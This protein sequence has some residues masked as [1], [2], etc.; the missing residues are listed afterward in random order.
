ML[1]SAAMRRLGF[2]AM[3][4]LGCGSPAKRSS[5]VLAPGE[6]VTVSAEHAR[7]EPTATPALARSAR[8]ML[9]TWAAQRGD[10]ELGDHIVARALSFAGARLGEPAELGRGYAPDVAASPVGYVVAWRPTHETNASFAFAN[11]D[12]DAKLASPPVLAGEVATDGAPAMTAA[13]GGITAACAHGD[14]D[15][16]VVR[17][18]S[19]TTN[20]ERIPIRSGCGDVQVTSVKDAAFA[21]VA[22][23]GFRRTE[24]IALADPAA[25]SK[26]RLEG[27]CDVVP[28][29]DKLVFVCLDEPDGRVAYLRAETGEA[30]RV[31]IDFGGR[32]H[33][34][35]SVGLDAG[36][37]LVWTTETPD[38]FALRASVVAPD[39]SARSPVVEISPTPAV[40]R[41]DLEGAS[42]E[43][44]IVYVTERQVEPTR[45]RH[46]VVVI[47]LRV[48]GT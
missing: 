19:R 12:D 47:P 18:P 40:P 41:F 37:L 21:A 10:D 39:G 46:D 2:L 11:V 20:A 26:V 14:P 15:V 44:W 23:D 35:R 1:G 17:H 38:G 34:L 5:L 3:L 48:T 32:V 27:Q 33:K 13:R 24:I 8:R 6:P 31:S 22:T 25:V 7:V 9:V 36:I 16:I 45:Y 30:K 28:D 4:A 43:A 29:R 42:K